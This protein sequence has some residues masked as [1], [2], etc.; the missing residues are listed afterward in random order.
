MHSALSTGALPRGRRFGVQAKLLA[1]F[2]SMA[3]ITVGVCG[4]GLLSLSALRKPL[5]RVVSVS[6]PNMEL[7]NRLASA[8]A[9]IALAAPSLDAADSE[10]T[11]ARLFEDINN[12]GRML[13][14]L[15][16]EVESRH[17]GEFGNDLRSSMTSL[18]ATLGTANGTVARRL[19]LRARRQAVLVA[20]DH[21]ADRLDAEL[22]PLIEM[23]GVELRSKG[24]TVQSSLDFEL[25]ALTEALAGFRQ[26]SGS[27]APDAASGGEP[28]A[29]L[30]RAV[31][32]ATD[33]A[34]AEL[35][36]G[37]SPLL[38][39]GLL[40][41]RA[42]LETATHG[43]IVAGI[44]RE[45]SQTIDERRLA[46]LEQEYSSQTVLLSNRVRLLQRGGDG[47]DVAALAGT[48]ETLIAHGW[49]EDGLFALRRSETSAMREGAAILAENRQ[50]AEELSAGV[51]TRIAAM[52][53]DAHA[54]VE[55]VGATLAADRLTMMLSA[56]ASAVAALLLIW[57]VGHRMIVSRLRRLAS[58][59]LA[60]AGG[61]L[62][63]EIPAGGAD[64]IGE[65]TEALTV[66]RD[67]A[68]VARDAGARAERERNRATEERSRTMHEIAE[69]IEDLVR[70]VLHSVSASASGMQEIAQGMSRTARATAEETVM[71]TDSSRQAEDSVRAVAAA[72]AELSHS[73][74]A[75]R[76][77]V[78][79]SGTI[80]RDAAATVTRTNE[81]IDGL[82]ASVRTI[83]DVVGLI[84]RIAAQTNLLALNAT[85][86]A[87]HAGEAGKGFAVVA[88]EVKALAGEVAAATDDITGQIASIR[89]T[90]EQ[91]VAATRS[92]ATVVNQ[93][94]DLSL[95]V[96]ETVERQ[97][98]I[99]GMIAQNVE[100]AM[101]GA[102]RVRDTIDTVT[103]SAGT[104][105]E[106]ADRVLS[107]SAT[108]VRAVEALDTQV[109]TLVA[110][111]RR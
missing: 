103:R 4:S 99:T 93:L 97:R 85:I 105:G 100:V 86:E 111:M 27:A 95:D 70:S 53:A 38:S 102:G 32:T 79:R 54:A 89:N 98:D 68:L 82:A 44:L 2:M 15:I 46:Q 80:A 65:M 39:R 74:G 75:V 30:E 91:V 25:D 26:V 87:A 40:R 69:Q 19:Y 43:S 7:A 29:A 22:T 3:A 8:S 71:A 64:E 66:F 94:N 10:A 6:L 58:A 96:S 12:R 84:S 83:G 59:M 60:I 33:N 49:G 17:D 9:G 5:D 88:A 35:R 47:K 62:D 110:R 61:R 90:T 67:T 28:L 56:A 51:D 23:L 55:T 101:T 57:G 34:R 13:T 11:R 92:I 14:A 78:L 36:E 76:D 45:A 24:D 1:A 107:A 72:T 109:G 81:A 108:V 73:I 31:A 52:R 104:A 16:N 106:T 20:L 77:R 21:D 50:R 41:F 37:L 42:A 63:S 18:L 48:V